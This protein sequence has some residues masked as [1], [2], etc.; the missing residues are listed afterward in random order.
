MKYF[1]SLLLLF[2]P[3]SISSGEKPLISFFNE[4]NSK[5]FT[6]LFSDTTLIRELVEMKAELR[7]GLL[8]LTPERASV[9]QGLNRAGIPVV[10]WLLLPEDDGYWFSMFNGEKAVR[11]YEDFVR[12][13]SEY[14]LEWKGIGIDL[15]LDMNDAKLAV[16]HP[17]KLAWKA[18]KRLYDKKTVKSATEL[19]MNLIGRMKN[20]GFSVE[21]YTIPF[22]YEDRKRH[23]TALQQLS[24]VVDIVTDTEIPMLYTSAMGNPGIIPVSHIENMPIALGSTGGGVK[25]EG[26]E[27]AS[28]TW[29][30]LERDILIASGL[31]HEIHIFC[32]EA[33][34]EKGYLAKIREMDFSKEPPDLTEEIARQ[35]KM[36][37]LI[38]FIVFVLN[39]PLIL[40]IVILSII[41]TI[42]WGIYK[43]VAFISG[44]LTGR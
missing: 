18:Y 9:I 40:T 20:D 31:T 5:D 11:R 15:E 43:A 23:S 39:Y 3:F 12:W 1:L 41:S 25:I 33:A 26:I 29:E 38:G 14:S 17:W 4:Q 21:S 13:S 24:G 19:Y 16:S 22:I 10:A 8:D 34:W 2:L 27:L 35:K 37:N 42:I 36:N 7:I 28:L 32:L 44:K 30:Q 6:E